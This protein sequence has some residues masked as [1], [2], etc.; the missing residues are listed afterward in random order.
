GLNGHN[1]LAVV[2]TFGQAYTFRDRGENVG[3][4]MLATQPL[5]FQAGPTRHFLD[6]CRC[7]HSQLPYQLPEAP[8]P[9][10]PPP[11]PP[12]KPPPPPPPKPP[13]K[14]PR[15]PPSKPPPNPPAT[16]PLRDAR[17]ALL[18]PPA[19]KRR[20]IRE[21]TK[22]AAPQT[23]PTRRL[24]KDKPVNMATAKPAK[25]GG[26]MKAMKAKG[27]RASPI[28]H[29]SSAGVPAAGGGRLSPSISFNRLST[30]A[31]TPPT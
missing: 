15:D 24:P 27:T 31:T 7:T 11:P 29:S 9:P 21:I 18:L 13:P 19:P 2:I 28:S 26:I 16:P 8:P 22:A 30:P 12:P 10:L 3:G 20:P 25:R 14:P 4:E 17:M 5:P 23:R 6:Q 1:Q